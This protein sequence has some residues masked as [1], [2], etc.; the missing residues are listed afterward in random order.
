M[1]FK[2]FLIPTLFALLFFTACQPEEEPQPEEKDLTEEEAAEIVEGALAS[3]AEGITAEALDAAYV[4]DQYAEKSGGS[5]CGMVFDSTI[6]RSISNAFITAFY[7]SDWQWEV[8]CNDLEIPVS[9]EFDR[10]TEGSY[11]TNR[12]ESEDAAVGNWTLD[13]LFGGDPYVINGTYERIGQQVSLVRN[14]NVINSEVVITVE[15]LVIDKDDKRIESGIASFTLSG[16]VVGG[17]SFSFDGDIIFLGDMAANV[18]IN[19]NVYTIE[20]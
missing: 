16:E 2:L 10:S 5:P 1:N 20:L 11:T 9:M 17:E 14:E 19:G 15:D 7:S 8:Y 18:I 12:L 6:D 13:N 4:G 3:D